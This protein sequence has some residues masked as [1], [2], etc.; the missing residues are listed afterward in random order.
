MSDIQL[1]ISRPKI[2]RKYAFNV[3]IN[4]TKKILFLFR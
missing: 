1:K 2:I 3:R 4:E